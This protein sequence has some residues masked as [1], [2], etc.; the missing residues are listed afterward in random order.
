MCSDIITQILKIWEVN[1]SSIRRIL[2]AVTVA[3]KQN[4]SLTAWHHKFDLCELR[5]GHSIVFHYMCEVA[6]CRC[7]RFLTL[8]CEAD[9]SDEVL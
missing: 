1:T 4:E 6:I 9:C 5:V 3:N 7:A 8:N 2:V